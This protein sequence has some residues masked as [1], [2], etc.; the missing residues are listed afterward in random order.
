[1]FHVTQMQKLV[2]GSHRVVAQGFARC[3][4]FC[5]ISE[6]LQGVLWVEA[7]KCEPALEMNV[8]SPEFTDS[9][10]LDIFDQAIIRIE[11]KKF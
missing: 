5:N 9:T 3:E 4:N 8:R 2:L 7:C 1:M 10:N 11:L 6:N